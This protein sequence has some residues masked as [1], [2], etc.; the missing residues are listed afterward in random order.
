MSTL[1][2]RA[3]KDTYKNLI[4]VDNSNSGLDSTLRQVTDGGGNVSPV[5]LSNNKA[6]IQPNTNSTTAFEIKQADG[7]AILTA[8]ST[9]GSVTIPTLATTTLTAT[10][11]NGVI[12]GTGTTGARPSLGASDVCIYF[13]TTIGS[14]VFW[15]GSEWI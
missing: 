13:D 14:P 9:A 3:I 5:Y 10:T 6:K 1:A 11:I 15:F 4:Q 8:N 12:I 2:A 7:T